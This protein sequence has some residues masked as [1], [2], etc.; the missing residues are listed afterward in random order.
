[1]RKL[2]RNRRKRHLGAAVQESLMPNEPDTLWKGADFFWGSFSLE[3]RGVCSPVVLG[4]W[5]GLSD[6]RL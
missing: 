5:V 3:L 6:T 1:M 4:F 2:F